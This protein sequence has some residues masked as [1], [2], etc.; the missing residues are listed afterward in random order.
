M[1]SIGRARWHWQ[2]LKVR[3]EEFRNEDE[4]RY[5]SLVKQWAETLVDRRKLLVDNASRLFG[6]ELARA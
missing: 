3:I 5:L 1:M 4:G 6:F 2:T